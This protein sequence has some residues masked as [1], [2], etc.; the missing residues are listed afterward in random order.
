MRQEECYYNYINSLETIFVWTV[1]NNIIN[2]NLF[3]NRL[4]SVLLDFKTERLFN[5]MGVEP[6]RVFLWGGEMGIILLIDNSKFGG[7]TE[8]IIIYNKFITLSDLYHV[9]TRNESR[10]RIIILF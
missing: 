5:R 9:P 6:S 3:I 1:T 4:Q 10:C 8:Y 7:V 2:Y